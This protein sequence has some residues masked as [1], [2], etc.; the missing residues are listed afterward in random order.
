MSAVPNLPGDTRVDGC[1]ESSVMF[2]GES[3]LKDKLP[4]DHAR[5]LRVIVIGAGFSGIYAGIRISQRLKN[6]SLTIYE[7]D[8]E[9]GGTWYE[10]KY[11]V[12]PQRRSFWSICLPPIGMCVRYPC[13]FIS[14]F[15]CHQSF[16]V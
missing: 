6:V 16:V 15:F 2:E 14:I 4:V 10:N 11:P 12:G 5:S 3:V 8:A 13:T 1:T 9:N 7:K